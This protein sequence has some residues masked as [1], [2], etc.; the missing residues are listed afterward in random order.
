M[1][2]ESNRTR[3]LAALWCM[4]ITLFLS[5]LIY[6]SEYK[7]TDDKDVLSEVITEF[8]SPF[9]NAVDA[10]VLET[11]EMNGV[12]LAS[13][14]DRTRENVNGI[15]VLDKGFNH[16]YRIISARMETSDYSSVA[17]IH[18]IKIKNQL[19]YIINGYNLSDEIR[20]YGLDYYAYPHPGTL[21][22]D[23]IRETIKFELTNRQF[24]DIFSAEE[25]DSLREDSI[26][27]NYDYTQLWGTSL[28]DEDGNEITEDF[29][30]ENN[31]T[32]AGGMVGKAE[33]FILYVFIFIV[34]GI[35]LLITRNILRK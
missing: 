16:R 10:Y 28:Y 24:I 35:G 15:A 23:R 12:L 9:N 30:I 8:S 5:Y 3:K 2:N 7:Y 14:K 34:L 27:Y 26:D 11:K 18:R 4:A 13:F 20:Y 21:A 22:R 33:L 25:I 29:I 19:Y 17:Q 1:E 6:Y 32:G 31:Y